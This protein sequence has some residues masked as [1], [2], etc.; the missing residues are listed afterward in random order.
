MR[1]GFFDECDKLPQSKLVEMFRCPKCGCA[2]TI[3]PDGMCCPYCSCRE[4][5]D[6]VCGVCGNSLLLWV[7]EDGQARGKCI[8][9]GYEVKENE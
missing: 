5:R 6:F 4:Y 8:C 3:A 2:L 9:C 1:E 7:A